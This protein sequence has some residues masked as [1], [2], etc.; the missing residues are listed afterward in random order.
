[1]RTNQAVFLGLTEAQ[2]VSAALASAA[3]GWLS[4]A[5]AAAPSRRFLPAA[6]GE[7]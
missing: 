7:A 6:G 1:V 4:R 5:L 2:W 3:M